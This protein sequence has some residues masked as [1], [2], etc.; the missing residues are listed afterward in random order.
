MLGNINVRKGL[1]F[2]SWVPHS[3]R[4]V[5]LPTHSE[6]LCVAYNALFELRLQR[7]G[8]PRGNTHMPCGKQLT[9]SGVLRSND[10]RDK[11]F[12]ALKIKCQFH[13]KALKI[14]PEP[15]DCENS[16]SHDYPRNT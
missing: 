5:C 6:A 7:S 11:L 4:F 2:R 10:D 16:P 1:E 8:M 15:T 9:A 12:A 14:R 3:A 13:E